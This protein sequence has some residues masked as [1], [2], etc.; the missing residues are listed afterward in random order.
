MSAENFIIMNTSTGECFQATTRVNVAEYADVDG[1]CQLVNS[2]T[3]V[4]FDEK[5]PIDILSRTVA[6][7]EKLL[8]R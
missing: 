1:V 6:I 5:D 2:R 7:L 8:G 4:E 3:Q